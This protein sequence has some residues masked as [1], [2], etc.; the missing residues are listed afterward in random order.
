MAFGDFATL[1]DD[2]NRANAN[3]LD[4]SWTNKIVSGNGN[5][6]LSTNRATGAAS[7]ICSAWYTGSTPG[8]DCE[9]YVTIAQKPGTSS[10]ARVYLRL[11][12]MGTATPDGYFVQYTGAAGTDVWTIFRLDNGTATNIASSTIELN[13]GDKLGLECIGSAI[14]AYAFTG[15][16]WTLLGTATDATYSAAGPGGICSQSGGATLDDFFI[17]TVTT[18]TARPKKLLTLGVG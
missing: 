10:N 6:Q 2:F 12:D 8:A 1:A 15:G 3:P 11:A 13:N 7:G 5:M 9:A 4:G 14:S 16:A 17:G 18:S